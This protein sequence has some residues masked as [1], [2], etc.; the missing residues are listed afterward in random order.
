MIGTDASNKSYVD[1]AIS[2]L[3]DS[4]PGL[5]DTLNEI[6]TALGN[7]PAFATTITGLIG[8]KLPYA[9]G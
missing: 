8:E 4:A 1:G 7:D 5:L 9:G 6:A 2:A 3:I